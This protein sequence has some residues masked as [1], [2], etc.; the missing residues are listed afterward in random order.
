MTAHRAT[1]GL[2]VAVLGLTLGCESRAPAA[3]ASD[4]VQPAV[5][6]D[7][8]VFAGGAAPPGAQL[9]NPFKADASSMAEGKALFHTMNCDG[10]HGGAADGWVGPSLIDGRWIY[11][12]ADGAVFQ[13]IYYGRPGGMPAYGGVLTPAVTW[14]LVAYL[15]ALPVPK[16]VPTTSWEAGLAR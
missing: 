12:G 11:G 14:K 2:V 1:A 10:C 5:R 6:Y 3:A 9:T 7:Q 4:A 8:H 16:S 15:R 13:S